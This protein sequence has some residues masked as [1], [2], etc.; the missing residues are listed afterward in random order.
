MLVM[1]KWRLQVTEGP[2]VRVPMGKLR[3]EGPKQVF[4]RSLREKNDRPRVNPLFSPSLARAPG[5]SWAHTPKPKTMGPGPTLSP[6]GS[7]CQ[8][9]L[10]G[11]RRVQ[12]PRPRASM[13]WGCSL[14]QTTTLA[15]AGTQ[16]NV[17]SQGEPLTCV[18]HTP[19]KLKFFHL[20]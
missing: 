16:K 20:C 13:F 9:Y 8:Y 2:R 14:L 3:Q 11:L 5:G 6:E 10:L 1:A 18:C 12:V 7:S 17:E 19:Q 15:L 4:P